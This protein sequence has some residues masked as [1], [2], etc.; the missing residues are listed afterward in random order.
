MRRLTHLTLPL[1]VFVVGLAVGA[2]FSADRRATVSPV[3]A[4]HGFAKTAA[5]GSAPGSATGRVFSSDE[6]ML[7]A[8]MSAVA[9]QEPFLRSHR[10]HD[11]L[12]RLNSA[13]LAVLFGRTLQIDD[14]ERRHL[15][16]FSLLARW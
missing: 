1:L 16:L 5:A 13:E 4:G 6:E 15:V 7:T 12:G 11:L 10:L 8:L 9:E 14:Y 2:W 3:E